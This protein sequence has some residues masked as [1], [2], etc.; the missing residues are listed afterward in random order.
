MAARPLPFAFVLP[1]S[2]LDLQSNRKCSL[3]F[4]VTLQ[5]RNFVSAPNHQETFTD[6][7]FL[8]NRVA[9]LASILSLLS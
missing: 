9:F 6:L 8:D 3:K 4:R 5:L 1:S 7:T 2:L